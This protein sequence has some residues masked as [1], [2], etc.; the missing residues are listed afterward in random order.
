VLSYSCL[1][2]G[3][4]LNAAVLTEV[5]WIKYLVISMLHAIWFILKVVYRVQFLDNRNTSSM[6]GINFFFL[7]YHYW[8]LACVAYQEVW[9]VV[10]L[11][12]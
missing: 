6:R 9:A 2:C 12:L 11:Y 8:C 4:P 1:W 3:V 7:R 5:C 10:H